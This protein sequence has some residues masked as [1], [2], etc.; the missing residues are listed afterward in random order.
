MEPQ[1][2]LPC[3]QEPS[4]GPYPEPDR[5][6]P[7]QTIPSYHSKNRFN[8]VLWSTLRRWTSSWLLTAVRLTTLVPMLLTTVLRLT[9]LLTTP[10]RLNW[11]RSQSQ[12]QSYV[13]SDGQSASLSWNKAR[14][15]GLRPDF[16]CCQTVACLLM[17][18]ALSDERTGLSFTI[19][20]GPRQR[21]HFR[22]WVPW[23]SWSYFTVSD[24]RLPFSSPPT[25]RRVTVEVFDPASTRE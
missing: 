3:S 16:Y 14:V 20:T 21:S 4:T 8:I 10:V 7:N 9:S 25:T 5:S 24:S 13:T 11:T 15:R 19:T 12:S 18:S 2:S 22:V 23:D 1:G 17:W 6:S